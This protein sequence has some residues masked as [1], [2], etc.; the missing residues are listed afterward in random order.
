VR[1]REFLRGTAAV[2]SLSALT[3]C[4]GA[5]ANRT[6]RVAFLAGFHDPSTE[7][8]IDGFRQGLRDAGWIDGKNLQ[9]DLRYA[10]GDLARYEQYVADFIRWPADVMASSNSDA[11]RAMKRAT[12]TT[13]ILFAT[14]ADPV[15][16]D[17]IGV[18]SLARPGGNTTG[19]ATQPS[20]TAPKRLEL[21]KEVF[22]SIRRV[23]VVHDGEAQRAASLRALAEASR[24]LGIELVTFEIR[25][26]GA[27]AALAQALDAATA[28]GTD[29]LFLLPSQPHILLLRKV[30][31]DYVVLRR[32]PSSFPTNGGY[33]DDGGL[34]AY[35][36][37]FIDV[38]RTA[39][40]VADRILRGAKPAEIPVELPAK[41][42]LIINLKTAKELGFTIPQSILTRATQVI[43]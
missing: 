15:E 42:D 4:G 21:L 18:Q 19:V 39:A 43:Q 33:V 40:T 29:A 20:K 17:W 36:E 12:S 7:P 27:A 35:G 9:F 6:G 14:F 31:I 23:A 8:W 37:N 30:I 5:S 3:S 26:A 28:R 1:R 10:E 41:F 2:A 22:P 13:P 25:A 34:M 32:I 24:D 38:F 11:L 16:T